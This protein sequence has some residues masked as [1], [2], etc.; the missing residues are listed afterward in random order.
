MGSDVTSRLPTHTSGR[1]SRTA[2]LLRHA[3]AWGWCIFHAGQA[4]GGRRGVQDG[5]QLAPKAPPPLQQTWATPCACGAIS[6]RSVQRQ[7]RDGNGREGGPLPGWPRL[8]DAALDEPEAVPGGDITDSVPS[9]P[10]GR[11]AT[12]PVEPARR[13]G[14]GAQRL[15]F[16]TARAAAQDQVSSAPGPALGHELFHGSRGALS[17]LTKRE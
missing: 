4:R 6:P 3:M 5:H 14:I 12:P 8:P 17:I 11:S 15:R 16:I 1:S 7:R 13:A 2:A 9:R 10:P